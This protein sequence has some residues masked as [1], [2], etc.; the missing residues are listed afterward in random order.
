MS[1]TSLP[2]PS[3]TYIYRV[4]FRSPL[5]TK[6]P[7]IYCG[8]IP[9][10]QIILYI[11]QKWFSF[12]KFALRRSKLR[13]FDFCA[14]TSLRRGLLRST[15]FASSKTWFQNLGPRAQ[16]APNTHLWLV[17]SHFGWLSIFLL[18]QASFAWNLCISVSAWSLPVLSARHFPGL[19]QR[20]PSWLVLLAAR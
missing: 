1:T 20:R 2:I 17:P 12:T 13:N 11:L 6:T 19:L 15:I 3:L 7:Y 14:L 18:H 10:A 5:F 4:P 9:W 16:Q 8:L